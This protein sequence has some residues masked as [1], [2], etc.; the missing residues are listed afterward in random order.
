M[1]KQ[2][3]SLLNPGVSTTMECFKVSMNTHQMASGWVCF[4]TFL[5]KLHLERHVDR[6][7]FPQLLPNVVFIPSARE[8]AE[9]LMKTA[10][11]MQGHFNI[12][13]RDATLHCSAYLVMHCRCMQGWNLQNCLTAIV[14]TAVLHEE[15]MKAVLK[16]GPWTLV[17]ATR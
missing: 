5:K 12:A 7:P 13:C 17:E 6:E 3:L 10:L 2:L 1:Q 9:T 11:H 8:K 15:N 4:P 14:G 16:Q